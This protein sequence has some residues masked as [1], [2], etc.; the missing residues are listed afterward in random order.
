MLMIFLATKSS[1]QKVCEFAK[2]RDRRKDSAIF[3]KGL[4]R[5]S[6]SRN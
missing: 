2:M 5:R 4:P 1:S 3:K 6:S